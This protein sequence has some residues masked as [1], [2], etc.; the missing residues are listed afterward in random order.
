VSGSLYQGRASQSPLSQAVPQAA[1]F[2]QIDMDGQNLEARWSC[3]T[4]PASGLEVLA[5]FDR[6]SRLIPSAFQEELATGDVEF[7]HRFAFG[8]RN[9]FTWGA[10]Y[11][12]SH[13]D[14]ANSAVL[15]FLPT[16]RDLHDVN[17][18]AQDQLELWP[19][20]V[21]L[22]LGTRLQRTAYSGFEAMPS[23][24]AAWTPDAGNT[25]WAAVSRAVRAPSRIDKDIYVPAQ[26]LP[27]L[28]MA[29]AGGPDMGSEYLTAYEAGWRTRMAAAL[30]ASLSSFYNRYTDLRILERASDTTAVIANGADQDIYGLEADVGWQTMRWWQWRAGATWLGKSFRYRSGAAPVEV[31]G[32]GGE[33]PEAQYSLRSS[34]DLAWGISASAWFRY[35]S[36]LGHPAVPYYATASA[37]VGWACRNLE[38]TLSGQDLAE[39]RHLEFQDGSQP[40]REIPRS[41]AAR[42][43]AHF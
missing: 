28:P 33:D 3:A 13:D 10:G 25:L 15:R 36:R 26:P 21:R 16:R 30:S 43:G 23:A 42:I 37:A 20:R 38:V 31:P 35:V 40:A 1:S 2:G 11:R 9:D 17:L 29:I 34:V 41:V 18:F 7:Q 12:I 24:R 32:I 22:T 6:T 27:A 8:A 5:Y 39:R 14:V 4:G 19:D